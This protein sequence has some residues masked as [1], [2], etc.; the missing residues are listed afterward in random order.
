MD[1]RDPEAVWMLLGALI[2]V[3]VTSIA[4]VVSLSGS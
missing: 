4:W 2:G 3:L 1:L